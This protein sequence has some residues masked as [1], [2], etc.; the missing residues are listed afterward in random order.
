MYD[1][2]LN[3]KELHTHY[4][5]MKKGDIIETV[6]YDNINDAKTYARISYTIDSINV[7][8]QNNKDNSERIIL[9]V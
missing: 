2:I 8:V 4:G 1:I 3:E 5:I 7:I 6:F 9:K